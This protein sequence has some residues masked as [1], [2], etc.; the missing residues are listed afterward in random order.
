MIFDAQ[1]TLRYKKIHVF[2][3]LFS[4]A[5]TYSH[6]QTATTTYNTVF[7]TLARSSKLNKAITGLVAFRASRISRYFASTSN[8]D[9]HINFTTA[10]TFSS[11][12][13]FSRTIKRRINRSRT[14]VVD[15]FGIGWSSSGRFGL[16]FG[17]GFEFGF[18]P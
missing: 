17:S 2:P 5:L 3:T 13:L 11:S 18:D 7:N 4:L 6:L 9:W 10:Q 12:R 8:D 15:E 1:R 14:L 16:W